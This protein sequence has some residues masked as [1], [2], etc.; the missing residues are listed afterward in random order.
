MVRVI[1]TSNHLNRVHDKIW[2]LEYYAAVNKQ[3]FIYQ[4]TLPYLESSKI[5]LD[6]F[7]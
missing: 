4:I 7:N 2:S 5:K 6:R 3:T 1:I